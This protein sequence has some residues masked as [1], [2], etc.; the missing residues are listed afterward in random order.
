MIIPISTDACQ[1]WRLPHRPSL[2]ARTAKRVYRRDSR[3]LVPL[4]RR[5]G[6]DL[7]ARAN[8]LDHGLSIGVSIYL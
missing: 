5:Q 2:L 8:E 1:P 4:P 7:A 6:S 3:R